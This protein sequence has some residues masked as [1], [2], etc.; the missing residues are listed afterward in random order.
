M[1]MPKILI[2]KKK[3]LAQNESYMNCLTQTIV[4]S[5]TKSGQLKSIFIILR[6]LFQPEY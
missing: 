3:E 5:G 1:V 6:E 4:K 2:E